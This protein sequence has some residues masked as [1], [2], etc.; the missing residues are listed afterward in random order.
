[1]G[2]SNRHKKL[3]QK[4]FSKRKLKVGKLAPRRAN[5]TDASFKVKSVSLNQRRTLAPNE[6]D[7]EA[8]KKK[9]S[10]MKKS[11]TNLNSRKAIMS[12]LLHDV[13]TQRDSLTGHMDEI[14]KVSSLLIIDRSRTMREM[15]LDLW[16]KLIELDE[17]A[18]FVL[19]LNTFLLFI[20]SAMTH[21]VPAIRKDSIKYLSCL[22]SNEQISPLV[23]KS[24]WFK[25]LR[26]FMILMNWTSKA[27]D[28]GRGKGIVVRES[29]SELMSKDLS[30]SRVEEI[31]VLARMIRIGCL[32]PVKKDGK[33]Q[34]GSTLQ[35]HPLTSLY[36]IPTEPNP[37]SALKLFT[38][39]HFSS[40]L[41]AFRGTTSDK[42]GGTDYEELSTEDRENRVRM[43]C[44]VFGDG[45]EEGLK[46][47]SK[48]ENRVLAGKSKSLLSDYQSIKKEYILTE[49][50]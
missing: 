35:V 21:L 8:F 38:E 7:D 10:I 22:L 9:L 34:E 47:L 1:M 20:N 14:L 46:E 3:K 43:L 27:N 40:N 28:S 36:M 16:N 2:S 19:H 4:D 17:T 23:V 49:T 31:T 24:S 42:S 15:N 45:L 41:S 44:E 50:D 12:E 13:S 6:T 37:Y 18:G 30:K 32:N 29:S 25:L 11:T 26:N 33:L 5:Q 39:I 48:E